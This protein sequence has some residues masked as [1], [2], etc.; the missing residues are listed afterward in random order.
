MRL[1]TARATPLRWIRTHWRGWLPACAAVLAAL[2]LS[3]C[4]ASYGKPDRAPSQ[5]AFGVDM[6][7][8]GL[9]SEALFRFEQA[10][11][12]DPD[13]PRIV[14]N[15][16]VAAEAIGDFDKARELYDRAIRLNPGN[17]EVKRN[18]GRFV[19]FYNNYNAD[20]ATQGEGEGEG[21]GQGD[22]AAPPAAPEP[23][24]SANGD[25]SVLR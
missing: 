15:M 14:N 17:A 18:Y 24:Q 5:L 19:E 3:A 25:G 12:L 16:A 11:R 23:A 20:R 22:P 4:G 9:W 13:N 10:S 2:A 7:K 8:R 6:A 1:K 21:A